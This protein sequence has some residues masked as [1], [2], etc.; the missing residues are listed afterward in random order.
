M[1]TVNTRELHA[2]RNRVRA[3]GKF[4]V[5]LDPELIERFDKWNDGAGYLKHRAVAAALELFMR[6][7]AQVREAV[8]EHRYAE[9]HCYAAKSPAE[10]ITEINRRLNAKGRAGDPK[11]K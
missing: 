10:V 11:S 1:T 9:L 8:I 6:V 7:D 5:E 2:N 4:G 3:R